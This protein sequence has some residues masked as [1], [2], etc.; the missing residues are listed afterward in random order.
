VSSQVW[1]FW[2]VLPTLAEIAGAQ[3]PAGL[4]GISMLPALLGKPQ[5]HHVYL[6]WEFFER[7]FHQAVRQGE[8]K[9]VRHG[10]DAPIELYDLKQDQTESS[11]VAGDHRDIVLRMREILE[12][13]RT[14]S[15]EFPI[16]MRAMADGRRGSGPVLS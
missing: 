13:A 9:A 16:P 7:G 2:D 6:Y 4:D 12:S 1:A 5:K 8:W 14:E 15:K 11:D 10:L 3:A